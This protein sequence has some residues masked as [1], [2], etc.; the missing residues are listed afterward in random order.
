MTGR[1]NVV[2]LISTTH[3]TKLRNEMAKRDQI[4]DHRLTRFA[5]S[6]ETNLRILKKENATPT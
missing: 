1:V 3:P 5:K 6:Y 4:R 2:G